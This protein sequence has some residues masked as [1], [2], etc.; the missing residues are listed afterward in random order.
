MRES[1]AFPDVAE[2][3]TALAEPPIIAGNTRFKYSNHGFGLIGLVIEAVT[4]EPYTDWIRHTIID[5]AGLAETT[6]DMPIADDVPV[7]S[8][9][10]GRLPFGRRV[11]IP[12]DNPTNALA[13]ATGFVSTAGDLAKFFAAVDPP[14]RRSPLAVESR[15]E[16]IRRQWRDPPSSRERYYG[17]GIWSGN[18]GRWNWFGHGGSFQGFI[19]GTAGF[20]GHGLSVSILTNARDGPADQWVDG[21]NQILTFCQAR[22]I[23]AARAR[24]E[25]EMVELMGRGGFG[26]NGR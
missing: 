15:R 12:G 21:V 16:M 13:A 8:G 17:L 23:V 10:S 11:V 4:G 9:H 14:A 3:R 25:R 7:A 5:G 20:P 2:L 26:A 19:G 1:L 22:R 18:I 6:P 24:L